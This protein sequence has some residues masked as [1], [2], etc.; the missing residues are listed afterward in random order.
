MEGR[1][2]EVSFRPD[3]TTR[4]DRV[5][6]GTGRGT[7]V[8]AA[9]YLRKRLLILDADLLHQPKELSRIFVHELFHFVWARLGNQKRRGYEELVRREIRGRAP[10]ELGWSAESR[11]QTLGFSDCRN[12]TRR[13]REYVCESFCDTA[14]WRLS[15]IQSHDE[16]TLAARWRRERDK[17]FRENLSP[18]PLKV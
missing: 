17:W 1:P 14:A 6:S 12:R 13:W 5:E 8:H 4:G 16:F 2:I 18:D 11:K 9:S 10:G 15:G 7:Q 3:L